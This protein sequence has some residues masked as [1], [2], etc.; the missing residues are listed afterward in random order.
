MYST[1][2]ERKSVISTYIDFKKEVV[3]KD[4]KYKLGDL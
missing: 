1:H 2:N 4:L 3:D